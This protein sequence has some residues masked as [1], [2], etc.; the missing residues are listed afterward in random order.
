MFDNGFTMGNAEIGSPKSIQT[1]TAVTSQVL[2]AV[3]SSQFGGCSFDKIDEV[4]APYAEMNY[5]K[6]LKQA[7]ELTDDKEKQEEFAV[8]RTNKDIYDAMQALE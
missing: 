1:A 5:K 3:A 7:S 4:L 8:K 6:H 2:S